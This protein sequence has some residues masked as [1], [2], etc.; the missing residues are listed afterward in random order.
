MNR[1]NVSFV[2][3]Y[4]SAEHVDKMIRSDI[5]HW[6][7][8]PYPSAQH[9]SMQMAI[10]DAVQNPNISHRQIE[11]ILKFK[12]TGYNTPHFAKKI[13][14]NHPDLPPDLVTK[15]AEHARHVGAGRVAIYWHKNTTSA[16][17][18][19]AIDGAQDDYD[20][21]EA[22]GYATKMAQLQKAGK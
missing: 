11:K 10:I 20:H 18:Q 13:L 7:D 14:E 22:S 3:K 4:G 6:D 5:P 2:M 9:K 1:N 8:L 16:A 15:A 21:D 17:M 19:H 12:G